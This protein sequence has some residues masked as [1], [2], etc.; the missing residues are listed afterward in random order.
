MAKGLPLYPEVF[1]S[2]TA[3]VIT[4][5]PIIEKIMKRISIKRVIAVADCGLLSVDKPLRCPA[6]ERSNSSW[7][8]QS[9]QFL[10]IPVNVT[11]HSGLS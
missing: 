1:G 9:H 6:V 10:R 8:C 2:N 5:K 3:Q 7:Q 4:L 11:A